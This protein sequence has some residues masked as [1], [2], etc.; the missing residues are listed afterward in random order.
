MQGAGCH[1]RSSRAEASLA[2][3]WPWTIRCRV[4][5]SSSATVGMHRLTKVRRKPSEYIQYDQISFPLWQV[6]TSAPVPAVRPID[7]NEEKDAQFE[8]TD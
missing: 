2:A 7:E 6:S 4:N 5:E 1:R 8:A 3:P